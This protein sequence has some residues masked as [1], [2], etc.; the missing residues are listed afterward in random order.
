MRMSR[1]V[2][3]RH[4]IMTVVLVLILL[5]ASLLV[6][7][8]EGPGDPV[9]F[10]TILDYSRC[11]NDYY[12]YNSSGG[13]VVIKNG[14]YWK[15]FWNEFT[16]D[17]PRPQPTAIE[18]ITW[19]NQMVLVAF[20]G[21]ASNLMK[22]IDFT[23]VRKDGR[24]LYAYVKWTNSTPGIVLPAVHCPY[25][26]I[27][28]ERVPNVVFVQDRGTEYE[29]NWWAVLALVVSAVAVLLLYL[30]EFRAKPGVTNQSSKKEA[31]QLS[32]TS[33]IDPGSKE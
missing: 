19:H 1:L 32:K 3:K 21:F 4:I 11:P 31:G 27:V 20:Y 2:E 28:V 13:F 5:S 6:R 17:L 18:N 16:S 10:E 22:D 7:E 8:V 23:S 30:R 29:L 15:E 12:G 24:T 9:E 14:T 33:G 25:H 26:I